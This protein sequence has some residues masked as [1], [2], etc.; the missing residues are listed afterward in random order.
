MGDEAFLKIND[1]PFE[2]RD[3]LYEGIQYSRSQCSYRFKLLRVIRYFAKKPALLVLSKC[4]IGFVLVSL[5]IIAV[6]FFAHYYHFLTLIPVIISESL[7]IVVLLCLFIQK[8]YND[9]KY[10]MNI[11]PYW[12]RKA[13]YDMFHF[14]FVHS[15]ILWIVLAIY[16]FD[17]YIDT[18]NIVND[19]TRQ[20]RELEGCIIIKIILILKYHNNDPLSKTSIYVG[21][22]SSNVDNFFYEVQNKAQMVLIP[23][24]ILASIMLGKVSY[25][26]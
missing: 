20:G 14:I 4:A 23:I 25:I 5:P 21:K 2:F 22:Y 10:H 12:V 11:S 7:S 17:N 9:N 3:T 8:L 16:Y 15:F 24:L 13:Y 26:I 1:D 18:L 6:N 19:N